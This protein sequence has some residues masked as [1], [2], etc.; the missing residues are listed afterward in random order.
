VKVTSS[1]LSS[2]LLALVIGCTGGGSSECHQICEQAN[3]CDVSER[4]ADVDCPEYCADIVAMQDRAAAVG[5]QTCAAEY[6]THLSC[7][8]SNTAN[9]CDKNFKGCESAATAWTTCMAGLCAKNAKDRNCGAD[10]KPTLK[11]F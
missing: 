1:L 10:G 6:N 2:L 11:P 8:G 3:V 4:P 7:W 5:A 9:I